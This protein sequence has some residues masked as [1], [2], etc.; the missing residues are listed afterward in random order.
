MKQ[1][2]FLFS[3]TLVVLIFS[4][5]FLACKKEEQPP[6]SGKTI[7]GIVNSDANFSLLKK[8]LERAGLVGKLDSGSLTV[9]APDNEAFAASG[10]TEAAINNL[11]LA[12]LQQLL[13]YHVVSGKFVSSSVVDKGTV[14]TL[15]GIIAKTT[16]SED[17]VFIN[18]IKVKTADLIAENGVIHVIEKVLTP[19]TIKDIVVEDPN[20]S[21]LKAAVVKAELATAL[22]EGSLTVFAP[23]NAAFEAS[24]INEA[25]INS[26]SVD[27]VK[28]ILLYHVVG[29]Q[30]L[31]SKVPAT[32]TVNTLLSTN[33]YA[34]RNINGVFVNGVA[35]KAAD[36][37]AANGV[38]HV[39]SKVLIP[40][41]KTIAAIVS[42]NPD[43]SLLLAAVVR[44]NLAG[45]VSGE[46]KYTVFAP[47]NEAFIAAGFPDEA[48]INA[49]PV[50]TVAAIVKAHLFR[51]NVFSSDLIANTV[52]PTLQNGKSLVVGLTPPSVKIQDSDKP[53]S[54]IILTGANI[55]AT[56]G[57]IHKIDRVI[58]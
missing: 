34:S 30:V 5:L 37:L 24:G 57:V 2:N 23:D 54:N 8:A 48:A 19:P 53:A 42:E 36:V 4:A 7:A 28:N 20:F 26:L 35:V 50:N 18:N 52:V 29:A 13:T 12:Q 9:F 17:K 49:A 10:I 41:T 6:T 1:I 32:D 47:T 16:K 21:I 22:S 45:A 39:I 3:K 25:A 43:L 27:V 46:G 55:I 11:P 31:S 15:S 44:A 40:P 58:L 14:K 38:I 51:T 33:I 56:N